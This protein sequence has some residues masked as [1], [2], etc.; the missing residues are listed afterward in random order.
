[1]NH[2]IVRQRKAPPLKWHT[3][4]GGTGAAPGKYSYQAIT[5]RMNGREMY[6]ID[7]H[8]YA[9]GKHAHY[10][11]KYFGPR[12]YESLGGY[13]TPN[14][15]KA[16]ALAHWRSP[17]RETDMPEQYRQNPRQRS[18]DSARLA[19]AREWAKSL[20]TEEIQDLLL[21]KRRGRK[22]YEIQ[23]LAEEESK[24]AK[25]KKNPRRRVKRNPSIK[26][27]SL[28][29]RAT[30][31]DRADYQRRK[32]RGR[33]RFQRAAASAGNSDSLNYFQVQAK[34]G[35][36][37]ITLATF[38]KGDVGKARA[39]E[40]GKMYAKRFPR[41]TFRIFWPDGA[42]VKKN[43]APRGGSSGAPQ[44]EIEAAARLREDFSGHK[45]TTAR[46]VRLPAAKVG[47]A[48]GPLLAVAY[49]TTRDG[50]REKYLHEFRRG[51]RPTLAAS[52]DGRYLFVLGG[53]FRFTDRGI[54]DR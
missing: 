31:F 53:A 28:A 8:S 42:G 48:I 3:F 13:S 11:L 34:R 7:P 21:N 19:N 36:S 32:P 51:A 26:V 37:W 41:N 6:L 33:S 9:N 1:M 15:A 2:G 12:G 45:V 49:E 18:E 27:R 20:T 17:S 46:Q 44:E 54:V 10:N 24:R 29:K 22:W 30:R 47:L 50:K 39:I 43:P 4:A 52:S 14:G 35:A 5:G 16:H 25:L 38:P 23:A 40:Y